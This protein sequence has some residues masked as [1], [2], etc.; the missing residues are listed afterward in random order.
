MDRLGSER[1]DGPSN[2]PNFL[3]GIYFLKNLAS[4]VD[5]VAD[6]EIFQSWSW[7]WNFEAKRMGPSGLSMNKEP[8]VTTDDNDGIGMKVCWCY[9]GW[10]RFPNRS[11]IYM[12]NGFSGHTWRIIAI[13]KC[14]DFSSSSRILLEYDNGLL[15]DVAVSSN[16]YKSP[17]PTRGK[18]EANRWTVW[19]P[20][21]D[22]LYESLY[23]QDIEEV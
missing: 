14:M 2:I 5:H 13:Y 19:N 6:L 21:I 4:G 15:K 22:A 7:R 3:C 11:S 8:G 20:L 23:I 1:G 18:G 16:I 10:W 9:N 12:E 17:F